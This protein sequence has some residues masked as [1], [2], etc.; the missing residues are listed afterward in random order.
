MLKIYQLFNIKF[1]A[2]FVG[3]MLL[4]SIVS[5]V[6]LKSIIVSYNTENLK[7]VI[8]ISSDFL[9]KIESLEK[10]AQKIHDKTKYR[11]TIIDAEGKVIAET[12]EDKDT[13]DNHA[14]RYEVMMTNKLEFGES[15]RYSKTIGVDFLYVAKKNS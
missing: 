6:G 10:F 11:V 2:L 3:V 15:V 13:M 7:N 5:Y 12:N 8:K 4:T 1:V 14:H 9:T